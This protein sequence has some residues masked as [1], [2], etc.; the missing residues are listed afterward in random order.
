M[1]HDNYYVSISFK[2]FLQFQPHTLANILQQN[3]TNSLK[4]NQ[5]NPP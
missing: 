2:Y 5:N 1:L 3:N 4:E